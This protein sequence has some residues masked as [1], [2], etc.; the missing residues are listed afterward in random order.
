[1]DESIVIKK[2]DKGS[3]VIIMD[4][5]MYLHEGKKQLNNKDFYLKIP[6]DLTL[7]FKHKVDLLNTEMHENN[8]I[9]DKTFAYLLEGGNRTSIFYMLPKVH[10]NQKEPPGRPIVS[11][12]NSPTEKIS[13]LIDIKLQKFAQLGKSFILDTAD[14]LRKIEGF[15]LEPDEW[16]F[17]LD[18]NS[19]YTNIPHEEGLEAVREIL[20]TYDEKPNSDYILKMLN[21][22]LKCNCFRFDEE[23]YLQINGTAMGMTE[24]LTYAVIFMNRFEEKYVYKYRHPPRYG[25]DLLMTYGVFLKGVNL[26]LTSSLLI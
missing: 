8:Q 25:F 6:K 1:M 2:A 7:T 5:S 17:S 22:V 12:V 21:T 9:S 14:F 11:S 19:L 26:N 18:V 4:R 23:F 3:N 10:K 20:S 16:L 15:H 13:Q 24:A